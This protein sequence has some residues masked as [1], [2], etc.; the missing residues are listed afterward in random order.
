MIIA[1]FRYAEKLFSSRQVGSHT[2]NSDCHSEC[3]EESAFLNGV[4]YRVNCN[5]LKPQ[6][7]RFA[8]NDSHYFQNDGCYCQ[9]D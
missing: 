6:I 1:N 5:H 9:Y 2:N 3:N 7:L 4:K 8:Q